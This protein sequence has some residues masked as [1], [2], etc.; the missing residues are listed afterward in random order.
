MKIMAPGSTR[1]DKVTPYGPGGPHVLRR[2]ASSLRFALLPPSMLRFDA[3]P[4][5]SADGTLMLS[6]SRQLRQV[7]LDTL[8]M[9]TERRG[10]ER[11]HRNEEERAGTE[12]EREREGH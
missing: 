9:D 1:K 4:L 8:W 5:S 11:R 2:R 7:A 12:E 10:S 6:R 3:P